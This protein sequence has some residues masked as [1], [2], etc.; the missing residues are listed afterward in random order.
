MA[1]PGRVGLLRRIAVPRNLDPLVQVSERE[2]NPRAA[3]MTP[4]G[5]ERIWKTTLQLY[6]VGMHPAISL[7]IRREGKVVLDRSVGW[8]RGVAPGSPADS[9]RVLMTPDT[10]HCVFS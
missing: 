2:Q 8:A 9:E 6:R 5:I 10:P 4:E 3:G 7:C 1:K